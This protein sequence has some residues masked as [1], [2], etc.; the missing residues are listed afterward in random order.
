M[1]EKFVP[2]EEEKRLMSGWQKDSEHRAL[3]L[4]ID[5][6]RKQI[7]ALKLEQETVL[8]QKR[9]RA[10]VAEVIEQHLAHLAEQGASAMA[11]SLQMFAAGAAPSPT[12]VFGSAGA[13]GVARIDIGP[14]LAAAVGVD[15]MREMCMAALDSV[16]EGLSRDARKK[17]LGEISDQLEFDEIL[18]ERLIERSEEAGTPVA[19]R[20]DAN[21][22]I[23]LALKDAHST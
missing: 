9:S 5:R 15:R 2:T 22:H 13:D 19:R 14:L 18:E 12:T 1:K 11:R 23:V 3:K 16:P 17:R 4:K 8:A 20:P 21:P 7:A 6:Q 10:E